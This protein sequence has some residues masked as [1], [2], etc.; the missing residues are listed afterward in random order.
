MRVSVRR[1]ENPI[2]RVRRRDL[3]ARLPL[4]RHAL[5]VRD[6]VSLAPSR[7]HLRDHVGRILQV[8]IDEHDR[9]AAARARGQP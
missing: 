2:E 7:D 1:F 9:I 3:E 5:A 6:V 8:R 4:A